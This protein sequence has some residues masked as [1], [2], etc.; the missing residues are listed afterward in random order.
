M[1]T[2]EANEVREL[3]ARH[4]EA[5]NHVTT[6]IERLANAVE[7]TDDKMD[8][9]IEALGQNAVILEK[10]ANID[11]SNKDSVNRLHKRIDD[12][13]KAIEHKEDEMYVRLSNVALDAKKGG[14]LYDITVYTVKALSWVLPLVT[15][16]LVGVLWLIDHSK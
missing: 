9:V 1:I 7:K 12:V 10:I 6:S 14:E 5:I 13:E 11:S 3:V 8:K 2:A 16:T 4:D 15:A